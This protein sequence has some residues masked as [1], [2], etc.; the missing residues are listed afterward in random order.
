MFA[1]EKNCHFITIIFLQLEGGIS[2]LPLLDPSI[3]ATPLAPSEWRKRLEAVNE[4]NEASNE[5]I[6]TEHILLDVRNGNSSSSKIPFACILL[7]ESAPNFGMFYMYHTSF[8]FLHT[9]LCV[10]GVEL[11]GTIIFLVK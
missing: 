8:S 6:N 9:E 10:M 1:F 5:S 2:H 11:D 3:R 4:I 7:A